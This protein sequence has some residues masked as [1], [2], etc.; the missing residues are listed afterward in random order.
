MT[1]RNT[2]T[3]T[4]VTIRRGQ[5]SSRVGAPSKSVTSVI[6]AAVP[7]GSRQFD[8]HAEE[9]I[10]FAS[11]VPRLVT[12]LRKAGIEVVEVSMGGRR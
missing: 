12:A 2:T 11:S 9:W 3:T 6:S 10:V 5:V 4:T 1:T 8:A 7:A